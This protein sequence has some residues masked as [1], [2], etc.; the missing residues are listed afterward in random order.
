MR[1]FI[2]RHVTR[3]RISAAL[4]L[5]AFPLSF[6]SSTTSSQWIGD[7]LPAATLSLAIFIALESHRIKQLLEKIGTTEESI[8]DIQVRFEITAKSLEEMRQSLVD[9]R[10]EN[11]LVVD[12]ITDAVKM[13][14]NIGKI[15]TSLDATAAQS[16]SG[17]ISHSFAQFSESW[18][19]YGDELGAPGSE[20]VALGWASLLKGVL[21][22][23]AAKFSNSAL[24][25]DSETYTG[26]VISTIRELRRIRPLA[27]ITVSQITAMLP[28]EFFN[29]PQWVY[30]KK[31]QKHIRIAHTWKGSTEYFSN[32][33][34]LKSSGV[35]F[36]RYILVRENSS[37][38]EMP[39]SYNL[40]PTFSELERQSH[41]YIVNREI[42]YADLA[43]Y[44]GMFAT[45]VSNRSID[46]HG[47]RSIHGIKEMKFYP[48]GTED[49][50]RSRQKRLDDTL[51]EAFQKRFH[52]GGQTGGNAYVC[53]IPP[54][55]SNA[56]SILFEKS[57]YLP[58]ITIFHV[59]EVLGN[60]ADKSVFAYAAELQPST[61]SV[62]IRIQTND[63]SDRLKQ[64]VH[65]LRNHGVP[66]IDLDRLSTRTSTPQFI[67][68]AWR[69][70]YTNATER[71][72]KTDWE[73][74]EPHD[75]LDFLAEHAG[76]D[77]RAIQPTSILEIGCGRG[78]RMF[79]ALELNA[80]RK[81]LNINRS[82][83]SILG[84]DIAENAVRAARKRISD[85]GA[86]A[87]D[88]DSQE[89]QIEME[90]IS[91]SIIFED[92][93]FLTYRSEKK[94]DMV[95][96]WMCFHEIYPAY[97]AHYIDNI[98]RLCSDI[99]V[100]KVFDTPDAGQR[101]DL[102]QICGKIPKWQYSRNDIERLFGE[103][104]SIEADYYYKELAAPTVMHSDGKEAAKRA[105]LLRKKN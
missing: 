86:K 11:N 33:S 96:D 20:V 24:L 91:C 12:R 104:F 2:Q 102:P 92:C 93:D 67:S 80:T 37:S 79:E 28:A 1:E 65:A 35:E 39:L 81:R 19:K 68:R 13:I 90:K 87:N 94:F 78:E 15:T 63:E 5:A 7:I 9:L 71:N 38:E 101:C 3:E 47:A 60:R 51:F 25:V 23:Q 53:L 10:N 26:A 43:G 64:A 52:D 69:S 54:E 73:K 6:L 62:K 89:S 55:Q 4:A 34:G 42:G 45:T 16:I 77:I 8:I 99:L 50:L 95:I 83:V 49:E 84:V 72:E 75:L 85:Y 27:K 105:Y 98:N 29:W 40:L 59:E 41:L 97:R 88:R 70:A 61:D 103:F 18:N 76:I 48:I 46:Y 57:T 100:L 21:D 82:D 58:E 56:Y 36:I 22:H 17:L 74:I 31:Q 14:P 44:A 32:I 30:C 66:L